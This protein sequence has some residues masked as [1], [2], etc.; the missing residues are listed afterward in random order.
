RSGRWSPGAARRSRRDPRGGPAH[1]AVPRRGEGRPR[2]AQSA[3]LQ[4]RTSATPWTRHR[5]IDTARPS[6]TEVTR[7]GPSP[8]GRWTRSAVGGEE[9]GVAVGEERTGVGGRP[10]LVEVDLEVEVR[11]GGVA[12]VPDLTDDLAGPDLLP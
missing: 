10:L 1:G 6:V 9:D 7:P 11:T 5:R 8:S 2:W 12:V 4:S 3:L